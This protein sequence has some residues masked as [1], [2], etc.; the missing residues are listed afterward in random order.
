VYPERATTYIKRILGVPF[1][2]E[3]IALMC[4]PIWKERKGWIFSNE[5]PSVAHCLIMF[6]KEFALVIPRAKERLKPDISSWL[7]NLT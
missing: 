3:I 4:W 7:H 5:D 1:G 2:M 6:K